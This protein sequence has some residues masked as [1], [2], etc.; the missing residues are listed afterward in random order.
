MQTSK[1]LLRARIAQAQYGETLMR[2]T[3]DKNY[4]KTAICA[5]NVKLRLLMKSDAV[6]RVFG[7]ILV[8]KIG[9]AG[10]KLLVLRSARQRV[11]NLGVV[12]DFAQ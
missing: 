8:S 9:R 7:G 11:M 3:T 6:A 4:G 1:G 2:V 12:D 10:C 5:R